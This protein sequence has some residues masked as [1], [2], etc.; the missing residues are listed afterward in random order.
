ML[1]I[2]LFAHYSFIFSDRV[3]ARDG[4]KIS[5]YA[6]DVIYCVSDFI[7]KNA[8]KLEANLNV[9]LAASTQPLLAK[10]FAA[11]GK[12][13]KSGATKTQGGY[14]MGQLRKLEQTVDAT[15]PRFIR[16][17]KPN[18]Q[19]I[20]VRVHSGVCARPRVDRLLISVFFSVLFCSFLFSAHLL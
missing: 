8:D 15:W 9:L 13:K 7:Q 11:S 10:L 14:F 19:K 4:F 20:P 17:V 1:T 2:L 18:Q 3:K 6:G 12:V 5:H 16:C